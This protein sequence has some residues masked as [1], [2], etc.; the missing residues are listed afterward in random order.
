MFTAECVMSVER[1][2]SHT[3]QGLITVLFSVSYL[4]VISKFGEVCKYLVAAQPLIS[5]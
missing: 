5:E 4:D 1:Y 2:L 3:D